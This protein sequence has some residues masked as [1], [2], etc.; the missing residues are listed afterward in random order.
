MK[1]FP[2]DFFGPPAAPA[3][4]R[5]ER[6]EVATVGS[7]ARPISVA[8]LAMEAKDVVETRFRRVWVRGE[9]SDFKKH[10]NGQW[11]FCLRDGA[12]QIRCVVWVGDQYR[13][14][15]AP[16]DGMQ[17]V[18]L[19]QLTVYT[20]RGDLQLKVT[21]IDA[22][23]DGLWRKAMEITLE[24]LRKEGLLDEGRKRAIPHYPRCIAIVT[25]RDGAALHDIVAVLRKRNIGARVV[26]CPAQVQGDTAAGEI[27]AAIKRVGRWAKADVLIVGRGGGSKDDLWAFNDER[28]ARAVAASPIPVISAVGHE[29]DLTICDAVADLRAPTPTAAAAAACASR[30]EVRRALVIGRREM[31]TVVGRRLRRERTELSRMPATLGRLASQRIQR[32]RSGLAACAAR[33]NA[34]SPLAVLARGYAV[35]R[36]KEGRALTSARDFKRDLEF[37]LL[38][39]DGSVDAVTK[40][41]KS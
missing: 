2:L 32:Q 6:S 20:A 1:Q 4:P 22:E 38:L 13:I 21:K 25:S 37:L 19:G 18:V 30:D 33:L 36:D 39:H 5:K 41:V 26:V 10:R 29:V 17:V 11:Y 23:G 28:V 3:P 27:A 35:A 31:L 40:G 15:A 7:A 16:D 14:P 9:I 8:E 24:K 34:L 12:S